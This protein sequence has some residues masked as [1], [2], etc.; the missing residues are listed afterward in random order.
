M[1]TEYRRTLKHVNTQQRRNQQQVI[2]K[3]R[4]VIVIQWMGSAYI[5]HDPVDK[6]Q[7]TAMF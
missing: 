7:S 4:Y 2:Q 1:I 6:S 3:L 5:L